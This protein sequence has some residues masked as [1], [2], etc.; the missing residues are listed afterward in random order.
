MSE[1][2]IE[3]EEEEHTS[4]L[5]APVFKRIVS[6]LKPHWKWVVGFLITIMLTSRID[7][8]MI[9]IRKPTTHFQC[10]LSKLTIRLNTGAV[11]CEVCSSS[12]SSISSSLICYLRRGGVTPPL[13]NQLTRDISIS[14]SSS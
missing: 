7:V 5:T 14:N 12:S 4:Q 11:N 9:V 3:L 10:G 8:S 13:Q 2:L 1:E 6:L